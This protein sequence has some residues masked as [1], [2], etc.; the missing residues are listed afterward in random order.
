MFVDSSTTR[1]NGKAYPRHLLRESYREA[2]KVKHR[3]IANLSHCKA[4]EVEAIRLALRHK[5]DLAGMVAA[6]GQRGLELVQGASVGAVWLLS[7]LAR[8]LGIVA[9]LGSDRQGKLALWQVIARVLDQGSRLSAVRLAGGHAAGAALGMISF[10]E[11]DLY[12]N[13]DWLAN[14]QADI[15]TR[16]FA[17]RKSASAPD[18]FLYDVT[19][20]YLEG[21]QNAFAAFGY[22]RDRKSGKRQIVIGL[23]CDADG[24]PLSIELFAGNTSDV[25]TF[26]SQLSKAAARFGAERVTFVGDR[27]M[28]KAPQRAELRAADFHYITAITKAQI[29]GLIAA[30][31]LQ[32]DLFE[33]ALAEVEGKDG[34]RYVLRRNPA[35][36]EEL[37]ASREDKLS[38][39]RTAGQA[40]DKYLREHPRAAAKTQVSRLNARAKTL[41]V[42]KFVQ[43]AA[44]GRSV[45][46]TVD[47]DALTELARLD[48][49][50][51]LRTD[52]PK[53]VV[54][55]DVVHDRY[56][57][58][59][60]V[61]WAFRDS[62]S[63]HLEMRPVYLRAEN[64]TR[65][66]AVVVMLAYLMAQELRRRWRDSDLTVQE[67]LHRLAGLC[68]TEV[69][70]G[71]RASYHQVPTPRDDVRQLFEAASIAIPTALPLAPARV[72]T[73]RK[74]PQRR[75]VE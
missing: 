73:K 8:E 68:V 1:L 69:R 25:K 72:A 44:E 3:T 11:D 15:E 20:T 60:Q 6:A 45:A 37:A 50:Y 33:E 27:G 31:V 35:R 40:A 51:A 17:R 55:K 57:D 28:I 75:K 2:G 30:G 4:E 52:L 9:A 56:K 61:E 39:L 16:L 46:L 66:H 18:V 34:E 24:R 62:K 19:S 22:N 42:D 53:A 5:A 43:I 54:S 26:S 7:Q 21:E 49:C 74:L 65:G 38:T 47:Q 41:H 14:N 67:G 13:L 58:L 71:G 64:R 32:M 12:A 48:G 59:A 29:D 70:I 10:D 23:L 63:V 36:A